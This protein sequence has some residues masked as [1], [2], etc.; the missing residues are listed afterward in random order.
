MNGTNDV[1]D[2]LSRWS[3]AEKSQDAEALATLLTNDF[4]AVGPLGFVLPRSAYLRRAAE[5]FRIEAF[6]LAE[7]E[8][9]VHGDAAIVVLRISQRGTARG[10]AIPEATRATLTVIREGGPWRLAAIQHSFIAGTPGAPPL[11]G[12]PGA[13]AAPAR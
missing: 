1:D 2:F 13:G 7:I 4:T 6:S 5:G 8:P 10:N 9:R 3:A 12:S 11:P